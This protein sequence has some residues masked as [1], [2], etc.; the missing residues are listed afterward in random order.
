MDEIKATFIFILFII[1][2]LCSMS[3]RAEPQLIAQDNFE[4][5]NFNQADPSLV[6]GLSW[7]VIEGDAKIVSDQLD[8]YSL[9]VTRDNGISENSTIITQQ[10]IASDNFTIVFDAYAYYSQPTKFL[11][12]YKDSRNYY[13]FGITGN[14][15]GI[16]R[17]IDGA[18][19]R[20][21]NDKYS[22]STLPYT[23]GIS[24]HYKIHV[25]NTGFSI[26]ILVDKDG[27]DNGADY[28]LSAEDV[29]P[30]P[31]LFTNTRFGIQ[32]Y[33][34]SEG[35]NIWF[36]IDNVAVYNGLVSDERPWEDREFYVNCESG[37]DT[38][39]GTLKN[40]MKTIQNAVDSSLPGDTII[41]EPGI[42]N[43][44]IT[45]S[46]WKVYGL[47]GKKLT[48]K[49]QQRR[50]VLMWGFDTLYAD[51]IRIEGFN[52]SYDLPEWYNRRGA[53][54]V[55]SN[56]VD[57]V[58]NYFYNLSFTAISSSENNVIIANN[59]IY[60][61][62]SGIM[63][64]GNNWIVENNE[65]KRLIHWSDGDCDYSRFFG[66]NGTITHN[67]FH[68][69]NFSEID[70]AH[71]DCF[72]TFDDNCKTYPNEYARDILIDSNYCA[73]FHQGLMGEA[74]YC[75]KSGNFTFSNNI[76]IR[77][78]HG[79]MEGNIDN[80]TVVN[81]LFYGLGG[82]SVI[83]TNSTG[84]VVKNNI[85]YNTSMY[86]DSF[87]YSAI[88]SD[89]NLHYPFRRD[90]RP[91]DFT[92]LD[93]MFRDPLNG[94][95][96]LSPGS[97]AID[98]GTSI[99]L[100]HDMDNNPR[101][102]GA[103]ID[104]GPYEFS[105][106]GP[107][108]SFSYTPRTG[109]APLNVTL[110]ARKSYSKEASITS[111]FW[112][113]GDGTSST[114]PY[115]NHTYT[116]GIFNITLYITDSLG[117]HSE[118]HHT[119]TVWHE[120]D[121]SI[122]LYLPFDNTIQDLSGKLVY[123]TKDNNECYTKGKI[124]EA[125]CCNANLSVYVPQ[126]NTVPMDNIPAI[127]IALWAKKNTPE[128]EEYIVYKHTI[129]SIRI[130]ASTTKAY[131]SAENGSVT[132]VANGINDTKWHHY[133]LSYNGTTASLYLD[134]TL[135]DSA[136]LKGKVKNGEWWGVQLC[137]DPWGETFNG[138]IDEVF[139]FSRGLSQYDTN[140]LMITSKTSPL[141]ADANHDGKITL[142]ELISFLKQWKTGH[143]SIREVIEAIM[144]WKA[145]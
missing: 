23:G 18:T 83:L 113:L 131:L 72:Q 60:A 17:V 77:G 48:I 100:S 35:G 108:A 130:G 7:T 38:D 133:A 88:E 26:K 39:N 134:G 54:R 30:S 78:Y 1:L 67:I 10:E 43:E 122:N 102:I 97:P 93:P 16:Y 41:V 36:S 13:F 109:F 14:E 128:E 15:Y 21:D 138:S 120:K 59:T 79:I 96:H 53:I 126:Y 74:H 111:Y 89:A 20:I 124:K 112:N 106:H 65:V 84:H 141:S 87:G 22:I 139:I 50:S 69:T 95:F 2:L 132:L 90:A 58:D 121:N 61:C 114:N 86:S 9:G 75:R 44:R 25:E 27:Y 51:N 99:P 70:G 45:F 107:V 37:N 73:D 64:S 91:G 85:F 8:G 136:S 28:E 105:G 80:I 127:T 129:Y 6:N 118:T 110:D 55:R 40:P 34:I 63:M 3:C 11:F 142:P 42:C 81:N 4:D 52:I 82:Q 19:K 98:E 94:D 49:A 115:I 66:N 125:L 57:V 117:R 135:A 47:P 116:H 12:L 76:F 5:V 33:S 123:I 143:T 71:V 31:S 32:D 103:S 101:P 145:L 56:Y 24:A 92:G 137:K 29:S 104:I 46:K 119:V 144:L 68:G 62:Q 140:N